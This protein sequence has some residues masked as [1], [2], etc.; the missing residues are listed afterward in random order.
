ME[1][2]VVSQAFKDKAFVNTSVYIG[3][4]IQSNN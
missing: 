2:T 1:E 3:G 4:T